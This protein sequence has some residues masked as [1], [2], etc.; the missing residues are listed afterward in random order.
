MKLT[1]RDLYRLKNEANVDLTTGDIKVRGDNGYKAIRDVDITKR[2]SIYLNI[3]TESGLSLSCSDK[4]LLWCNN[5]G[6]EFWLECSKLKTGDS[7]KTINGFEYVEFIEYS[8][9]KIDLYD[10]Q[11]DDYRYYSNDI[12]SHNSSLIESIDYTLYNKVKGKKKKWQT[13]STL[14]NRINKELC[15]RVNFVSNDTEVEIVRGQNPSVLKLIEND[16]P[17]DRAG[18]GNVNERIQDYVGVDIETFKSFISMSIND[19]KN[20]ISLSAEEKK[21]LLDKLFNLETINVLN[22][23]LKNVSKN[24]KDHINILNS[25]IEALNESITSITASIE[26][27]KEKQKSNVKEEIKSIKEEI[28]SR[29]ETYTKLKLKV[30]KIR[31]KKEQLRTLIIEKNEEFAMMKNEIKNAQSKIDLYDS[32]KC[33]ECETDLTDSAHQHIRESYVEKKSSIEALKNELGNAIT[34]YKE[35]YEEIKTIETDAKES[36]SEMTYT[37]KDLKTRLDKLVAKSSGESKDEDIEE[38][39]KTV[40]ELNYKKEK[41]SEEV[42]DLKDKTLFYKEL[43]KVFSEEGVKRTIIKNIIKPINHFIL[44]NLTHM[45]MPFSVELDETFSATIEQFGQSIEHDS[46]STGET[47]KINIAIMIAYLKLIRTKRAMN[48]LFL[49]EVFASI[50]VEG[51]YAILELLKSF[52][53]E[54]NINIFL[55]HHSILSAE[56]FDRLIRINKDIFSEIEEIEI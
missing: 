52:A 54:Y 56:Y 43:S 8:S 1:I 21:L 18:K 5:D 45:N 19:F 44:E 12:I 49:D 42:T 27:V 16:I 31:D 13:L 17:Y 15:T 50:D 2:N 55:V 3:I 10:I 47:K 11:V 48:I 40:E 35:K 34:K 41:S 53:N 36:Y 6:D 25:E 24:N 9:E 14:P 26:K 51:I 28:T 4:H 46:L 30:G 37:L 33:G 29:K 38:F 32:G 22:G 23:I 7:I 39:M 20:F